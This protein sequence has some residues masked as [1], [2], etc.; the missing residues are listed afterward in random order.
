[1]IRENARDYSV[2]KMCKLFDISRSNYYDWQKRT[3][4][5]SKRQLE[6]EVLTQRICELHEEHRKK[7]GVPKMHKALRQEGIRCGKNR[8]Y[9]LMRA[10]NIC[11]KPSKRYRNTTQS[12][13]QLPL[14]PNLLD[15]NFKTTQSNQVWVSDITY[16]P[17]MTGWLYLVVVLDLFSRKVIGW[18]V[19]DRL[20]TE[21]VLSA[22]KMAIRNRRPSKGLIIHSDRGVQ[23][24]SREYRKLLASNHIRC[25]M[26][27][28]AN[29]WDNAPAESFFSLLKKELMEDTPVFSSQSS[30]KFKIFDYIEVYY[31]RKRIH[32]SLEYHSPENY[33]KQRIC[34]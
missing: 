13:H 5:K 26:S 28:K 29:C 22:V 10:A 3:A 4:H 7:Y 9:R 25:S 27:R 14:A 31:N 12:N 17:T 1:M 19:S 11:R 21:F 32:S 18:A 20:K 24:A 16:I 34:A 8:V 2:E 23:Y 30:A 15:R 33:E 6:D